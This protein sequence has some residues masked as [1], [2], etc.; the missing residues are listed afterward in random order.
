MVPHICHALWEMLGH[1]TSLIDQRWPAIDESALSRDLVDIV[2]QVNG[3]L[4]GRI[5]VSA[6]A[7]D[8]AIGALAL[9]DP[10]VQRF[11]ADKTIRKTIVVPGRLVNIVV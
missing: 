10:N 11:V 9:S 3:K 8:D 4:R 1:E 7:D 6:D 5:E 2:V